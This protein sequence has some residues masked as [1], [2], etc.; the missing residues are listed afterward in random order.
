MS[1]ALQ[2]NTET[3]SPRDVSPSGGLVIPGK[4]NDMTKVNPI[5]YQRAALLVSEGTWRVDPDLGLVFGVKG[6]P[7]RRTNTAGYVHIKF[8]DPL[9][10]DTDRFALA[11]RVIWESVHG[12]LGGLLTINHMDGN[13]RNNSVTNLEAITQ[14]E[15]IWHA[16]RTGL[17]PGL[18]TRL[19]G[20]DNP[21]C[22]LTDQDALRVYE[23]AW[24]GIAQSKIAAEFGITRNNVGAIK[25][26][27]SWTHVT[28]HE[29]VRYQARAS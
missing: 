21:S 7:F 3:S 13:K 22:V 18:N 1:L 8:R 6:S 5:N 26:G 17:H 24:Q 29:S 16:V 14:A 25:H 10:W 20:A 9:D 23:M 4:G 27:W 11:H 15:N 12:S 28:G 2:L 19:K